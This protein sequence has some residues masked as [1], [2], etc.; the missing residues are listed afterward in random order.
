MNKLFITTGTTLGGTIKLKSLFVKENEKELFKALKLD[1]CIVDAGNPIWHFDPSGF[2]PGYSSDA[3]IFLV[4]DSAPVSILKD[5]IDPAQDCL[6]YH[7]DT[8]VEIKNLFDPELRLLGHHI[9][10]NANYGYAFR[11]IADP[12][13]DDKAKTLLWTLFLKKMALGFAA[14]CTDNKRPLPTALLSFDS[15][16]EA[17]DAPAVSHQVWLNNF[18]YAI[19]NVI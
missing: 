6:L 2:Q 3:A 19:D 12:A 7:R 10:R 16:R 1:S 13:I 11:I 5:I 9:Y 17:Y 4:Y 15:V 14:S 8:I 18:Y